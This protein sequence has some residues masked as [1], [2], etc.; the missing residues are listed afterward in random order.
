M[1]TSTVSKSVN[2]PSVASLTSPQN[3]SGLCSPSSVTASERI[4]GSQRD[5]RLLGIPFDQAALE[6]ARILFWV[7]WRIIAPLQAAVRDDHPY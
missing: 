4:V 1:G 5:S 6:L 2:L 3:C 7:A